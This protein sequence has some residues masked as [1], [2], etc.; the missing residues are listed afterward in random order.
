MIV[1]KQLRRL[2]L[3]TRHDT[4]KKPIRATAL[5]S[6]RRRRRCSHASVRRFR[7]RGGSQSRGYIGVMAG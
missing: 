4:S 2:G 7:I 5:A 1:Q 6:W 3:A